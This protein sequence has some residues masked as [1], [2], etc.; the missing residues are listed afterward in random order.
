[1][2]AAPMDISIIP[3]KCQGRRSGRIFCSSVLAAK[4]ALLKRY[5][6]PAEEI[7]TPKVPIRSQRLI[8]IPGYRIFNSLLILLEL[9]IS[10][11][12]F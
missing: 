10:K 4:M 11:R 12:T 7:A 9:T 2:K 6:T 1:M 5:V 3:S 8:R